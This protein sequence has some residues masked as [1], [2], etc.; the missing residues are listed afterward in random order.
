MISQ[1]IICPRCGMEIPLTETLSHQ[2]RE[3]LQ[4]ELNVEIKEREA[5]IAVREKQ[6]RDQ[7]EELKNAKAAIAQQV[8]EKLKVE[9]LNIKQVAKVEA[10][11]AIQIEIND[12]MLQISENKKK[13]EQAQ[14]NELELRKKTRE[15][16]DQKNNLELEITRKLDE[17]REKIRQATM[18][19]YAENHRLKD[20]EKDK[21][22]ED[23]RKTI[24]DLKRKAEQGSMQTQGEVLELDL[25]AAL[26]ARFPFDTIE[27]VAKGM[28]GADIIQNVVSPAGQACGSIIWET[29]RTKSWSDSWIEKLKDDQRLVNAEIAVIVTEAFPKGIQQFGQIDGIWITSP[30]LAGSIADVLRAG[31][32]KVSQAVLS[33]VNKGEK[34]E[35]LYDYLSGAPFRQKVEAIVE[36][37][38]SMKEDLDKEKRAA[39][40]NWSKREKQLEKVITSTA[41]MYGDMQ[42]IIGASLPEIKLLDHDADPEKIELTEDNVI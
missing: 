3:S 29:K 1:N 30:L 38:V 32:I 8:E 28:R 27:P 34:M 13:A 40:K 33:S 26:K 35:I 39:L 37:F 23:M 7:Q 21:Q 18:E 10:E 5:A 17:E 22:M 6:I 2:I 41:G 9:K 4:E 20:L 16:E 42:G 19:Q 14:N 24:D 15:L 11:A 31:L 12:L 25:E 36:A